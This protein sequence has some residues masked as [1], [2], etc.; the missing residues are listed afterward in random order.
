MSAPH[1]LP[2]RSLTALF[3]LLAAFAGTARAAGGG[4]GT[5]AQPTDDARVFTLMNPLEA[6]GLNVS[7]CAGGRT[8]KMQPL[9]HGVDFAYDPLCGKIF[10]LREIAFDCAVDMLFV[11]G[12]VRDPGLFLFHRPL[13]AGS[14]RVI[15]N[16]ARLLEGKGFEV[17]REKGAV[18]IL[19][20][21]I[22]ESGA[23]YVLRAGEQ[24][25]CNCDVTEDVQALLDAEEPAQVAG[26]QFAGAQ[27]AGEE[28]PSPKFEGDA[29][30]RALYDAM[31]DAMWEAESLS[32]VSSYQFG[33]EGDEHPSKATYRI[34][35][36][37]PNYA[38]VEVCNEQGE[39]T[40]VLVGD[41]DHFWIYWP[42]GKPRYPWEENGGKY[43]AEYEQY[44]D[45]Y[46]MTKRTPVGRHSIGHEVGSLGAGM[47]MTILDP[48]TFHGYSDS[49]QP[50]VD[51]VRSLGSDAVAD[52]ECDKIEVSIMDHQRSWYL[53]LSKKD[54]LPRK[55]EE[56]VRVSFNLL[57]YEDWS[58]V[59]LNPEIAPEQFQWKPPEGW[60]EWDFPP[61]E[62]G[63]L[64][65]GAE[66]PDFELPAVDGST[67]R[68]SDYR[69]N[70][71]WLNKWRCG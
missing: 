53:W 68:L 9:E 64:P 21:G 7:I 15:L 20:P 10:L 41:G 58:E 28:S 60:K 13:A 63:L 30:G 6:E 66:A 38:R 54:H 45:S 48:S 14:V 50:Y 16:G 65:P 24:F 34:W 37:K 32:W 39:L 27:F 42:P 2:A 71:V 35:L 67:I 18:R 8:S 19:D 12:R 29:A 61:I 47:S 36:K 52:E 31:I 56:V 59:T 69:G 5:N 26:A 22:Q 70:V 55:L 17:D 40:G 25:F 11:H 1:A 33:R 3:L 51:G 62:E 57:V 4:V 23:A 44:K 43:A 46:Y 49:L